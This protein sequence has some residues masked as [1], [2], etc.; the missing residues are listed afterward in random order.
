MGVMLGKL[1]EDLDTTE[2]AV[3][4]TE[5]LLSATLSSTADGGLPLYR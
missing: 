1:F 5:I 3:A 2:A 4:T